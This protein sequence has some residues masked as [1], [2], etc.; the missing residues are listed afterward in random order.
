MKNPQK[1]LNVP[2]NNQEPVKEHK[3]TKRYVLRQLETKEAE[4]EIKLYR[5]QLEL[6]PERETTPKETN[7]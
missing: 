2:L 5:E 1:T 7:D 3:F 6:F 4:Q